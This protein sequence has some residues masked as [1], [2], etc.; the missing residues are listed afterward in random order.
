MLMKIFRARD[1]ALF[2]IFKVSRSK[3]RKYF[4]RIYKPMAHTKT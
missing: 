3:E 1:C 4:Y 2:A